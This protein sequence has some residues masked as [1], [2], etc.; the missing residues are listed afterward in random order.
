MK[1]SLLVLTV[2][3]LVSCS[4]KHDCTCVNEDLFI[5]REITET[6]KDCES[7][8][9]NFDPKITTIKCTED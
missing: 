3:A 6:R 2:I 5:V 9:G 7:Y 1:K 8:E 4:K